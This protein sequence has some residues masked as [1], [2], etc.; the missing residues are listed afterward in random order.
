MMK[1]KLVYNVYQEDI[2]NRSI[3]VRNIFDNS[4]FL[5]MIWEAKKA[6][7]EDFSAFSEKVK[8]ALMYFYWSKCEY[9]IILSGWPPKDDFK[10][11]KIDVYEQV[12][13]NWDLFI[14]YLWENKNLIKKVK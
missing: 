14:K 10:K 8:N 7:G 3:V 13:L 5:N 1:N 9:E 6:F 12:M 11:K 4:S 2:N